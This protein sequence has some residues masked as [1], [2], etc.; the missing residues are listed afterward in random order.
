MG[1]VSSTRARVP[2]FISPASTPSL[3]ISATSLICKDEM[4]EVSTND[5]DDDGTVPEYQCCAD[6]GNNKQGGKLSRH[7]IP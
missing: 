5:S 4:Q 2:C 6:H 7:D 3:W 1:R